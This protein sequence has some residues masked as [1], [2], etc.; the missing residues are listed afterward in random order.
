MMTMTSSTTPMTLTKEHLEAEVD[1][2]E[3]I[4]NI[5]QR[6]VIVAESTIYLVEAREVTEAEAVGAVV[7]VDSEQEEMLREVAIAAVSMEEMKRIHMLLKISIMLME[8]LTEEIT[9]EEVEIEVALL[10]A[11]EDLEVEVN[12]IT[13][14]EELVNIASKE[15]AEGV[16]QMRTSTKLNISQLIVKKN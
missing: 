13:V 8:N 5:P 14:V 15:E 11:Q 10:E 7:S 6:E 9:E 3:P 12:R 1:H 16:K 4:T 2:G